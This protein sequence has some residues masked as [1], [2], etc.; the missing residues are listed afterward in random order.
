M[1]SEHELK[2]ITESIAKVYKHHYG[3][4]LT[5]IYLYGSYARGDHDAES[6]IDLVAIVK[7]TR[8][9]I[10]KTLKKVWNDSF[11][12]A[13]DHDVIISPSAISLDE[14]EQKKYEIPYYRNIWNEG[15]E[16]GDVLS[17]SI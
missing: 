8:E 6:D 5:R 9:N 2:L 16:I 13:Y 1:L 7:G 17:V 10:E 15:V 11:E 14:F 4:Q 3:S 12:I